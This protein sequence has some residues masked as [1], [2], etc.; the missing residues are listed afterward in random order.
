ML[1]PVTG[2]PIIQQNCGGTRIFTLT[3]VGSC[4]NCRR[5]AFVK[6]LNR[7][8]WTERGP[9][10]ICESTSLPRLLGICS[11]ER[12][13]QPDDNAINFALLN[14]SAE[15]FDAG[16]RLGSQH[17]LYRGRQ[18][19]GR[20]AER[21]AAAGRTVVKCQHPHGL[22]AEHLLDGLGCQRKRFGELRR[23]FAA[24]LGDRVATPTPTSNDCRSGGDYIAGLDP[25]IN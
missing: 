13:R 1:M 8:T 21:A 9:Q 18:C 15:L 14:Q 10:A 20:V 25:T 12:Q 3:T 16:F 23:V 6:E 17:G 4:G 5:K 19:A 7:S 24:S 11:R 22:C 2:Q